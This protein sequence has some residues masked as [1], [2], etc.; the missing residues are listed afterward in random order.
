MDPGDSCFSRAT[1]DKKQKR[2]AIQLNGT[3]EKFHSLF[4]TFQK[5]NSF[6]KN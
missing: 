1:P 3:Q 6:E 5:S 2:L 4:V